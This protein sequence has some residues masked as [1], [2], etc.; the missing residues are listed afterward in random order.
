M[1]TVYIADDGK[2]FTDAFECEDYEWMLHHKNLH[3]VTMY[4]K[5]GVIL[6]DFFEEETYVKAE[7]ILVPNNAAAKDLR[8][9]GDYTGYSGYEDISESGEWYWD[10]NEMGFVCRK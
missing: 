9:L 6:T 8:E 4:D 5:D 2:E 10:E 3:G 1:K 7:R